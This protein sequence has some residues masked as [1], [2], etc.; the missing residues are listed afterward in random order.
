MLPRTNTDSAPFW[1]LCKEKKLTFQRCTTCGT[2]RH[3]ASVVC[4]KC[5]S[6][7]FERI[8]SA[9]QGV[10]YSYVVFHKAMHKDFEGKT[11]YNV[12]TIDLAEGVRMLSNVEGEC[13][14]GMP[15]RLVWREIGEGFY[16]PV[17]EE[18]K[19]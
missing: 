1:E 15:V 2:V 6:T 14:C 9:G 11:P 16:L 17:F 19:T 4:P 7:E 13:Q 18:D 8:E 12:A 3:P 5:H 10:I